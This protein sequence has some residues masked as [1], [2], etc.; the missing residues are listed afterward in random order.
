VPDTCKDGKKLHPGK[1]AAS[2]TRQE[3]LDL[4]EEYIPFEQPVLA[5]S[6]NKTATTEPPA[7]KQRQGKK[8]R[9]RERRMRLRC[10]ELSRLLRSSAK[11]NGLT[12]AR[13][14]HKEKESL[15]HKSLK[16]S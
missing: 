13:K 11:A 9:L 16:L 15:D 10:P 5:D 2:G 3:M 1:I 12:L 14:G 7:K 8:S 4:E 6:S